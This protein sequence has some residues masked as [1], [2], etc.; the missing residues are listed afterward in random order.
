MEICDRLNIHQSTVSR[1]L[2]R[3]EQ[4]GIVRITVSLPSGTHTDLEDALQ[5]RYGLDEAIVVDCL[6]HDEQIAH[7][8]GAAAAFY[9]ETTVKP[10][11]VIGISSWSASLLAMVD[12]MHPNQRMKAERVVQILGGVGNPNASVHA[13]TLTRR[14]AD[15]TGATATLIPAPGVVGSS[16]AKQVLLKDPFVRQAVGLFDSITLA[17]VGVGALEPSKALASSGNVFS[18]EEL[19]MLAGKGAVGDICLRFFDDSGK[20]VV[21]KL[22]DRVISIGLNQLVRAKRV[23]A[24]AGG[25]RKIL[26]I[27]GALIGKLVNVL[28]TDLKTAERLLADLAAS[29][30][31]PVAAGKWAPEPK[32]R[33][34]KLA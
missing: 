17:L 29:Q 16:N 14:L 21:T 3:A 26:A 15:L 33:S 27:R 30:L 10:T 32:R 23:V 7:D 20:P 22:D 19:K 4:E 12:S 9:L 2:K 31:E 6:D 34:R 13:T 5:A 28:I 25:Q 1:V 11:D 8:L 24:V 18:A